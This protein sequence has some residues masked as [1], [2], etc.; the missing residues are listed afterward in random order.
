MKV[1]ICTIDFDKSSF[2]KFSGHILRF[3]YVNIYRK[4]YQNLL[5]DECARKFSSQGITKSQNETYILCEMT[6]NLSS[7]E[8]R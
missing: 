6:K 2:F 7:N 8:L 1:K 5:K 3:Y 4:F